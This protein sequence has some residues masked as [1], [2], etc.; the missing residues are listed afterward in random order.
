MQTDSAQGEK[1]FSSKWYDPLL[2]LGYALTELGSH[3]IGLIA[4]L[5]SIKL[6]Q[7]TLELFWGTEDVVFFDR[8][9]LKYIFQSAELFMLLGFLGIGVY[10]FLKSLNSE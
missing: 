7:K 6:I 4:I 1:R 9:K 2:R 3:I 5:A 10:K 8:L